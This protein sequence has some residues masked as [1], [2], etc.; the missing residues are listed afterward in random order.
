MSITC[1]LY[2]ILAEEARLL[3]EKNPEQ[4]YRLRRELQGDVPDEDEA[5]VGLLSLM[6]VM[7]LNLDM[8]SLFDPDAP[9][10]GEENSREA[11]PREICELGE[12][13]H[14]LHYIVTGDDL[15]AHPPELLDFLQEGGDHW[16]WGEHGYRF[17]RPEEVHELSG[18]LNAIPAILFKERFQPALMQ[19]VHPKNWETED[20]EWLVESFVSLRTF[21]QHCA[22]N[23]SGL[24][25]TLK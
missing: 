17:Y 12:A 6:R 22:E 23:Q 20:L 18:I 4:Y 14:G 19:E 3:E 1:T 25:I 13:W 11:T 9:E 5:Y 2:E 21:M 16:D 8:D 15:P 7:F 10:P 24:V